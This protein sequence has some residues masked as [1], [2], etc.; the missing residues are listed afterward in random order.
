MGIVWPGGAKLGAGL[1]VHHF[2]VPF[3]DGTFGVDGL[4]KEMTRSGGI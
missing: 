4:G 2:H 3:K 1:A